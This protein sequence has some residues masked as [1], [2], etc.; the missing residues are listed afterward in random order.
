MAKVLS[1]AR[2]CKH[3]WSRSLLLFWLA[4]ILFLHSSPRKEECLDISYLMLIDAFLELSVGPAS[5]CNWRISGIIQRFVVCMY[6]RTSAAESVDACRKHLFAQKGRSMES[7]P[8]TAICHFAICK[9]CMLLS[10]THLAAVL[11]RAVLLFRAR[12]TVNS[13][14]VLV[15]QCR[16]QAWK[17]K[18]GSYFEQHRTLLSKLWLSWWWVWK[19]FS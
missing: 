3:S 6:E 13:A 10:C 17:R 5:I 11:T 4:A 2:D 19:D 1:S 8:L 7:I 12:V 16:S 9:T 14:T 15:K 18:S